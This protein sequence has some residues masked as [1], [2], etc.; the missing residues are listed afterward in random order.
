MKKLI[1][2]K[3]LA[4]LMTVAVV[5]FLVLPLI[6][7]SANLNFGLDEAG[8][9]GLGRG[10]LKDTINA[11]IRVILSF[12]GILAVIIILWGGFIW[13]TAAGDDGKTEKARKLIIAGVV[14][15]V[16]I[17]AAYSI[18]YFVINTVNTEIN[19]AEE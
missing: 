18:A 10:D 3:T 8:E 7:S 16:I 9:I 13:M 15:I 6:A 11:I 19:A 5:S 14:G 17:L 12:L 1:S 2:K 4:A